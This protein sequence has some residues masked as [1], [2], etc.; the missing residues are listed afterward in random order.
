[1]KLIKERK[2]TMV[3]TNKLLIL[4]CLLNEKT[5]S[6]SD[7]NTIVNSVKGKTQ[8]PY[9]Y[10]KNDVFELAHKR[11]IE[12]SEAQE[13]NNRKK[14]YIKITEKGKEYY[15]KLAKEFKSEMNTRERILDEIKRGEEI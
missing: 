6:V 7:V 2:E 14:K 8:R 5:L 15:K 13:E 4:R 11:C 1:M 3:S 12:Y 9:S 10:I